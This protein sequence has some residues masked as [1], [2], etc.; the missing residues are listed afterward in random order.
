MLSEDE[1]RKYRRDLV[2]IIESCER[3]V[4]DAKSKIIALDVVLFGGE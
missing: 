2:L 1:I 3:Q 4:I